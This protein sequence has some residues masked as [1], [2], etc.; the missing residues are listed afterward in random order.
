MITNKQIVLRI[1]P[2]LM[3]CYWKFNPT[4]LHWA[5]FFKNGLAN[6]WK[7]I[8]IFFRVLFFYIVKHTYLL[9]ILDPPSVRLSVLQS[10]IICD[11]F[12]VRPQVLGLLLSM[13][14]KLQTI[15]SL[16]GLLWK[17][18]QKVLSR[19]CCVPNQNKQI[20]ICSFITDVFME[21]FFLML[22]DYFTLR[23]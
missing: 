2:W 16:K 9:K 15:K 8:P 19:K 23:S 12:L 6:F 5:I 13:L 17:F 3:K 1:S 22:Y 10:V 21:I 7:I 4:L 11:P 20:K 14:P 18:V